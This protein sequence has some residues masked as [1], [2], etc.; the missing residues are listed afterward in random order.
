MIQKD[1]IE[2]FEHMV[3]V[4]YIY[5]Q[6]FAVKGSLVVF[7]L[8]YHCC[9]L[10]SEVYL[11][12]FGFYRWKTLIVFQKRDMGNLNGICWGYVIKVYG[13]KCGYSRYINF[14]FQHVIWFNMSL[15]V[16]YFVPVIY[17]P[18]HQSNINLFS[19]F[20]LFFVW[21]RCT[22]SILIDTKDLSL[23]SCYIIDSYIIY[24]IL[25]IYRVVLRHLGEMGFN[26]KK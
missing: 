5:L 16:L 21:S 18:S 7:N 12:D 26:F 22:K 25:G 23:I 4:C 13:N 6:K 15:I 3:V 24:T 14:R 19:L 11:F 8:G 2:M 17:L 10:G 9:V 1:L 20:E